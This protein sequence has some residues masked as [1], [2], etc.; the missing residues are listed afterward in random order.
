MYGGKCAIC[1]WRVK[2]ELIYGIDYGS[3]KR[4]YGNEIHHIISIKNGGSNALSNLI[5]L[6]PNHHKQADWKIISIEEVQK[7]QIEESEIET[8]I[9]K[10]NEEWKLESLKSLSRMS[11]LSLLDDLF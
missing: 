3:T 11:P 1:G 5:L 7:H 8:I 9:Q 2:E 10:R 4:S 6:C